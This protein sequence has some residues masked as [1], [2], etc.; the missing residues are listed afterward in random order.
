MAQPRASQLHRPG[1]G[2]RARA[3]TARAVLTLSRGLFGPGPNAKQAKLDEISAD[4][5]FV[6]TIRIL[7]EIC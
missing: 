2:Q 5:N 6:N 3:G 7:F 4:I 1:G